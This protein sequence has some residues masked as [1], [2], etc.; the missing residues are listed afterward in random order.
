[1]PTSAFPKNFCWGAAPAAYGGSAY[2]WLS[3][4]GDFQYFDFVSA[5]TFLMLVG[6][7]VQQA[8]IERNRNR[9]QERREEPLFIVALRSR[10]S[11]WNSG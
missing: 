8:A 3:G 5:F 6:R 1:M 11:H 7:W 4:A 2:A 9:L 10:Q